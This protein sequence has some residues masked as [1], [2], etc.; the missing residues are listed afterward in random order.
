MTKITAA[1][2]R[3]ALS[4]EGFKLFTLQSNLGFFC[5][6]ETLTSYILLEI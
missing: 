6:A 1:N 2:F 5:W 4:P 3:A